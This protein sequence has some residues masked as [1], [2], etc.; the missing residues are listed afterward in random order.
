LDRLRNPCSCFL[1]HALSTSTSPES[2]Q[3]HDPVSCAAVADP[4]IESQYAAYMFKVSFA[5][6]PAVGL[7]STAAVLLVCLN[8]TAAASPITLVSP[9]EALLVLGQYGQYVVGYLLLVHASA[10][11]CRTASPTQTHT[12]PPTHP[13]NHPPNT[14]PT[15]YCSPA[16]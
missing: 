5:A 16:V 11:P 10:T 15:P 12:P 2:Y 9:P 8:A 7:N 1:G 3:C 6:S 4:F 13:L 14:P